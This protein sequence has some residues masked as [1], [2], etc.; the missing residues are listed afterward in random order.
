MTK[1]F[2]LLFFLQV[3]LHFAAALIIYIVTGARWAQ[4][5]LAFIASLAVGIS[6]TVA[7]MRRFN[8]TCGVVLFLMIISGTGIPMLLCMV[9]MDWGIMELWHKILLPMQTSVLAGLGFTLYMRYLRKSH[10]ERWRWFI[11]C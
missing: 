8:L 1:R 10:T 6:T 5:F 4:A 9:L 2:I 3:I 11:G 7:M